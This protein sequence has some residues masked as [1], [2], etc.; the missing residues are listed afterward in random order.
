M[1]LPLTA[2]AKVAAG[3]IKRRP[4]A[5]KPVARLP[6]FKGGV[7]VALNT[8]PSDM[9]VSTGATGEPSKI[10]R[11]SEGLSWLA[12]ITWVVAAPGPILL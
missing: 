2:A 9:R 7:E 10:K 5:S 6:M 4:S 1:L 3:T 8:L 11:Y 12:S